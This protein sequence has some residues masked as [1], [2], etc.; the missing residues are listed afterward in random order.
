[1]NSKFAVVGLLAIAV[2]SL[3]VWAEEDGSKENP[4][5]IGTEAELSKIAAHGMGAAGKGVCF[6]L[7]ADITLTAKW[8][9]IGTYAETDPTDYFSGIFDG[10]GHK[11]SNVVFS[12]AAAN[13]YRGFFNQIVGG[14]VKNLTV[15]TTGFG[16]T[17]LPSGEYGCAAIAG[18]AYNAVIENCVAEGMITGT[19]NVGGIVVRIRDTKLINCTNEADVTGSYTKVG[20]ICV[21]VDKHSVATS[22]IEGCVNTGAITAKDGENAG[23]DGVAGI[24]AY[25]EGGALTIRNCANEGFVGTKG[26]VSSTAKVNQILAYPYKGTQTLIGNTIDISAAVRKAGKATTKLDFDS[27]TG[28]NYV[29][30]TVDNAFGDGEGKMDRI[31]LVKKTYNRIL[32]TIANDYEAGKP[33]VATK[34]LVKRTSAQS[35]TGSPYDVNRAP[36]EFYFQASLDGKTWITLKEVAVPKE[37]R[38]TYWKND[39]VKTFEIDPAHYGAYRLYRFVTAASNVADSDASNEI[40]C[41]FQYVKVFGSIGDYA[42]LN[43]AV[44]PA[45]SFVTP[46]WSNQIG[47]IID[48]YT[49]TLDSKIELDLALQDVTGTRAIAIGGYSGTGVPQMRLFYM[50]DTGWTYFY[51]SIKYA[52]NVKAYPNVRYKVTIDGPSVK[53]NGTQIIKA[54]ATSTSAAGTPLSLFGSPA[55]ADMNG[56]Y[57]AASVEFWGCKAWTKDGKLALDLRPAVA[58]DGGG[59]LQDALTMKTYRNFGKA[60]SLPLDYKMH[61]F[62]SDLTAGI[63][64]GGYEPVVTLVEGSAA[65]GYPVAN[66]ISTGWTKADRALFSTMKNVIQYDIPD[67]YHPGYPMVMTRFAITPACDGVNP[68]TVAY[69]ANRAPHHFKLLASKDGENDWVTLCEVGEGTGP[70]MYTRNGFRKVT[71][72]KTDYYHYYGCYFDIPEENR[73]DYRHYRL[74][75]EKSSAASND[76]AQIALQEF[77]LY[78]FDGGFEAKTDPVEFIKNGAEDK[79]KNLTYFKTG[80]VPTKCDMT[81]EMTGEFTRVGT[82]DG[83]T[84]CLFCSR[85]TGSANSWTL[86]LLKGNMRLDCN[87]SGTATDCGIRANETHTFKVVANKLYVDGVEKATTGS[88]AFTPGSEIVLLASHNGLTGYGNQARF[89]LKGCTIK[90]ATGTLLRDYIPAVR[91]DKAGLFDRVTGSFIQSYGTTA[92]SAAN[93]SLVDMDF[94]QRDRGVTLTTELDRGRLPEGPL[95][96]AFAGNQRL[97]AELYATFDNA[98]RGNATNEWAEV[99]KLGDV[100]TGEDTLEVTLPETDWRR[101]KFFVCDK[102]ARNVSYT[103]TYKNRHFG[104]VILIR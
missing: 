53:I 97:G 35:E 20:G 64:G 40:K 55:G 2:S 51:S 22:L 34:I 1:M 76:G 62:Q 60:D 18:A 4:Y 82:D 93:A 7:T 103:Q 85:A 29:D 92:A 49:P 58:A 48:N 46:N 26:T 74:V 68:P 42:T 84:S 5:L 91:A 59:I 9:G 75:T 47:A 8:P 61:K 37:E 102:M 23:R 3:S 10:K 44:R 6:E 11:I 70:G 65:S 86:F 73:D 94:W 63:R 69:T 81:V 12:N 87:A 101:V 100:K 56:L 71:V 95:T 33:I 16:T 15:E 21:L 32:W 90:D 89:K 31:M 98:Y 52:S 41:S 39:V 66:I 50:A 24:V 57:N 27:S 79:D 88:T 19:H 72:D 96:F 104:T 67:D 38:S 54:D 28:T 99:V 17:S 43:R 45:G 14:T 30:Y 80:I 25:T 36:V 78:G 83:A 77:K 13:N